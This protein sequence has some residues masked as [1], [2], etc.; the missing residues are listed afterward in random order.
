MG[1]W[2][3]GVYGNTIGSDTLITDTTGVFTVNDFYY[4]KQEGGLQPP[5][6]GTSSGTKVNTAA[7]LVY[8]GSSNGN[9]YID[10]HGSAMQA[11]YD[12]SVKF[13]SGVGAGIAGWL[14]IDNGWV[15]NNY[16][17]LSPAAYSSGNPLDAGWTN[18]GNGQFYTG[19]ANNSNTG[20]TKI[21]HI[22]FKVP[23]FQYAVINT[24]TATGT[25]G[26]TPDDDTDW[27]NVRAGEVKSYAVDRNATVTNPG[28]YVFAVYEEGATGIDSKTAST[29]GI[30][31]P[32]PGG[33][34]GN[35]SGQSTRNYASGH[36]HVVG[37]DNIPTN[38]CWFA[39]FSGDSGY[40]RI[41]YDSYE[42]WIH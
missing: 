41:T 12:S 2:I 26:Q 19:D 18:T 16:N 32:K 10:V 34:F 5:P 21:G 31:L 39:A 20:A 23:K 11:Y 17:N 14:K 9:Y 7:D 29:Q 38:N 24:M 22:R 30:V 15:G 1:R 4:L 13:N 8:H 36:F 33:E 6:D 35:H 25:G 27:F 40:E 42:L 3:G 37:Y 28:G